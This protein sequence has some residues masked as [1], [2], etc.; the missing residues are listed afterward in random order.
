PIDQ[1][2]DVFACGV[3]LF[4][5]L[6]GS[7]LFPGRSLDELRRAICV[8]EIPGLR[9]RG[10]DLPAALQAIVAR[11]LAR[12]PEQRYPDAGA[13]H[14]ALAGFVDG[15]DQWVSTGQMSRW[16][17]GLYCVEYTAE[18][19]RMAVLSRGR[20]EPSS[21][22]AIADRSSGVGDGPGPS[23][24][25]EVISEVWGPNWTA[26]HAGQ[27]DISSVSWTGSAGAYGPPSGSVDG[28]LAASLGQRSGL[29]DEGFTATCTTHESGAPDLAAGRRLG[30]WVRLLH[31]RAAAD[32]A[33]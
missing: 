25:D 24:P 1:R 13:L 9:Q 21:G 4:E 18:S 10:R 3:V 16:L 22:A 12:D 17:R 15:S 26:T 28:A 29:G 30:A 11:A 20:A 2:S 33:S 27:R 32:R 8:A 14:R 7:R 23:P 5:L 19:R 6:T 31:H